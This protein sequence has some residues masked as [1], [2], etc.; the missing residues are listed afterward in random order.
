MSIVT[1][2]RGFLIVHHPESYS[3]TIKHDNKPYHDAYF[4]S[5]SGTDEAKLAIDL[6]YD[7]LL[8]YCNVDVEIP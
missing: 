7:L 3:T 4:G 1:H 5:F 2:Y 8:D 6:I